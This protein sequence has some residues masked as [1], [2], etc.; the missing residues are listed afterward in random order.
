MNQGTMRITYST[1]FEM[2][3][4]I[5]RMKGIDRKFQRVFGGLYLIVYFICGFREVCLWVMFFFSVK[6]V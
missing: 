4:M 2:M 6:L 3:V 5:A 1:K